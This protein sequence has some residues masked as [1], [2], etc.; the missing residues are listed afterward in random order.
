MAKQSAVTELK[1]KLNSGNIDGIYLLYGQEVYIK[2][3]Y[4]KK[5]LDF[6]LKIAIIWSVPADGNGAVGCINQRK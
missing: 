2:D 6:C 1:K 4:I 5:M 3:S